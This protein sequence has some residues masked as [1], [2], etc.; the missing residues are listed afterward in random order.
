[1][2]LEFQEF[3]LF[4]KNRNLKI[5]QFG[6]FFCGTKFILKNAIS[7]FANSNDDNYK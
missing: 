2:F 1:M 6:D 4:F 3:L 5:S 7:E